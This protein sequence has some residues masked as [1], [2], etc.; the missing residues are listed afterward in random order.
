[1]SLWLLGAKK[2][3]LTAGIHHWFLTLKRFPFNASLISVNFTKVSA[4][5]KSSIY[6]HWGKAIAHKLFSWHHK[7]MVDDFDLVYSGWNWQS[8]AWFPQY[9]S[10]LGNTSYLNL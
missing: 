10:R 6:K 8:D 4:A 5:F 7:I 3:V 2:I 9:F 1:M